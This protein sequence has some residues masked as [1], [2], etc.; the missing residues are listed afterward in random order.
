MKPDYQV[1]TTQTLETINNLLDD[2]IK[3]ISAI[4]RH[5]DRFYSTDPQMEPFM[6]LTDEGK[7]FAYDFGTQLRVETTPKL[8]S[9][10]M[11]RCVE[12]A[13][14]IDKGFTKQHGIAPE[15]N[16]MDQSLFVFYIKDF[17]KALGHVAKTG[18]HDFLRAWFDQKLDDGIMKS[19]KET[20]DRMIQFMKEKTSQLKNNQVGFC[21]SHDWNIY[22]LKELILGLPHEEYGDVGYLDG[23]VFFEKD[24]Q[25]YITSH[26]AKEP[27]KI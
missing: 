4:I 1:N 8:Y 19:P 23:L 2:G 6:G 26:Q 16:S 22:L 9:S 7:G 25:F 18:P 11:G 21:V 10:F 27:V 5:S 14:L 13:Y 20:S 17:I 15:H 24:N 12:T 3:K